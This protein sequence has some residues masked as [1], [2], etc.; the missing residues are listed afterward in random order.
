MNPSRL[1]IWTSVGALAALIGFILLY[2]D[3]VRSFSREEAVDV[4][5]LPPAFSGNRAAYA[6][7]LFSMF[8]MS[9]LAI[10]K[11]ILTVCELRAVNWRREPDVGLYRMAIGA[12][13]VAIVTV[14]APD[15]LLMLLWGEASTETIVVAMTADR[16]LDGLTLA[17]FLI[18]IALTIRAEQL[19]LIPLESLARQLDAPHVTPSKRALFLVVPRRDGLV[20]NVRIFVSVLVIALGLALY[21]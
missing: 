12:F 7:A 11:L 5:A 13:M 1:R 20:E 2:P 10:R 8:S 17:P 4:G 9:S 6:F 15:V 16:I 14:T 19:E 21:K 3:I 18:G